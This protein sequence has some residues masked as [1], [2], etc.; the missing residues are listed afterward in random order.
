MV[1]GNLGF[2][3]GRGPGRSKVIA[4]DFFCGAGGLTRGLLDAGIQVVA[5]FDCDKGCRATYEHNNRGVRFVLA[6]LK[7]TDLVTLPVPLDSGQNEE[8]IFAACAPCQPFSPQHRGGADRSRATLLGAFGR[9]VGRFQPSYVLVENVPGIVRVP[10][11]STFRRFCRTLDDNDYTHVLDVLDAKQFGVAQ[12]RRRLVLIAS[13]HGRPSLP[14][15]THGTDLH[16]FKTVRQSI[17]RFPAIVAGERDSDIPNHEAASISP[18]NLERL[19]H[20]PSDGGGRRAWPMRL[21]L[22]CHQGRHKGHTDVYGRMCWDSPAPALTSR[23][24]SISNGRYGH[25]DQDRAI[26][27]REAAAIQSFP[28]GYEFFGGSTDIAKQI[29]NAV[30]V[31]LAKQLG[32]HIMRLAHENCQFSGHPVS[33]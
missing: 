17:S 4:Y 2:S 22:Q 6:D 15:P 19:R 7:E 13:K 12:N 27:L 8:V 9:L 24:N 30:P 3:E 23:C 1:R 21:R 25:P 31:R 20:T 18:L 29:G 28:D 32:K 14:R 26:S 5:G 11:F 33:T 16:P 10:G